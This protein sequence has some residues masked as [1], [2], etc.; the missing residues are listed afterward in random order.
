MDDDGQVNLEDAQ[1]TVTGPTNT[2]AIA[3]HSHADLHVLDPNGRHVGINAKS[4]KLETRILGSV[5]TVL[6]PNGQVL[7]CLPCASA[8]D[9][10]QMITF[11][12]YQGGRYIIRL[13]GTS[14]GLFSLGLEGQQD[15]TVVASQSYSGDILK[16]RS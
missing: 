10:T 2:V 8:E 15:G 11:P 1:V 9:S 12:L 14:D 16:A 7:P 13:V 5:F 3:L 4:G 6:D